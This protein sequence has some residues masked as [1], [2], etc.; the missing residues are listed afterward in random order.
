ML[1]LQKK[2][3]DSPVLCHSKTV[4]PT[5]TLA[6]LSPHLPLVL[7]L[8]DKT[9]GDFI[10]VPFFLVFQR[11]RSGRVEVIGP[12]DR[13]RND[14]QSDLLCG[15]SSSRWSLFL[16][17]LVFFSKGF[18][19]PHCHWVICIFLLLGRCHVTSSSP[20]PGSGQTEA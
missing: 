15:S 3:S 1:L 19:L 2:K 20:K 8:K 12:D 9:L 13:D 10:F 7:G 11:W 4:G 16:F 6:I 14:I 17:C 18:C 5:P